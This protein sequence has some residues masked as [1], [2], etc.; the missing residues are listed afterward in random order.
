VAQHHQFS[1]SRIEAWIQQLASSEIQYYD[2]PQV[3]ADD[4]ELPGLLD[5]RGF[6]P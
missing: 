6:R 3:S 2:L 4:G 5:K 1:T